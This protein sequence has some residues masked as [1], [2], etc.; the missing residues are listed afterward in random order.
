MPSAGAVADQGH[1]EIDGYY[2]S[3]DGQMQR[4]H[5]NHNDAAAAA[6][7]IEAGV[8]GDAAVVDPDNMT[9]E[10]LTALGNVVGTV[11]AGLTK[12]QMAKIPVKPFNS[13]QREENDPYVYLYCCALLLFDNLMRS[14]RPIVADVSF[15]K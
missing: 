2:M 11:A 3:E 13:V 10:E 4:Q 5:G 7:E 14:S 9:Y 15:V 8:D 6:E 12:D 1:P